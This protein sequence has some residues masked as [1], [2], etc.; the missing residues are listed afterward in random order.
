MQKSIYTAQHRIFLDLLRQTRTEAGVTQ[1]ELAAML[2]VP[3]SRVSDYERGERR[4]DLL[5]L[6]A[7]CDALNLPLP[8]FIT[9]LEAMLTEAR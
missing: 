1:S 5:E 9:R 2:Q 7:Y 4:L 8:D 6:R 3:Q